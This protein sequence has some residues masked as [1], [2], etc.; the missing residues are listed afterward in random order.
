MDEI[1]LHKNEKL[2]AVKGSPENVDS[3]FGWE[4][5]YQIENVS[6]E[7]T[8]KNLNDISVHLNANLRYI[9]D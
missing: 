2:S 6:L 8:K 1:L 9:W 3:D 5:L 4:K 7:D